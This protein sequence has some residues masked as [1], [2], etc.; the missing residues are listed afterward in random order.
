MLRAAEGKISVKQIIKEMVEDGIDDNIRSEDGINS[1]VRMLGR[2]PEGFESAW[3]RPSFREDISTST[4]FILDEHVPTGV[5]GRTFN[6]VKT[7]IKRTVGPN[8][9]T[10][11]WMDGHIR[12][13]TMRQRAQLYLHLRTA[14]KVPRDAARRI[15]LE[16]LY[17]WDLVATHG[18]ETKILKRLFPW[19]T[20]QKNL[21]M[22]MGSTLMESGTMPVSE[23]AGRW[24]TGRTRAQRLALAYRL[25]KQTQYETLALDEDMDEQELLAARFE[26][27]LPYYYDKHGILGAYSIDYEGRE[28][29][30]YEQ[31]NWGVSPPLMGL[32]EGYEAYAEIGLHLALTASIAMSGAI[33][34]VSG[35]AEQV[36]T[37]ELQESTVAE[38]LDAVVKIMIDQ[39]MPQGSRFVESMLGIAP[40]NWGLEG[41]EVRLNKKAYLALAGFPFQQDGHMRKVEKE[42]QAPFY[43]WKPPRWMD[44]DLARGFGLD[45]ASFIVGNTKEQYSRNLEATGLRKKLGDVPG[46]GYLLGMER[47]PA[48]K[49]ILESIEAA[50][51]DV[52]AYMLA[53]AQLGGILNALSWDGEASLNIETDRKLRKVKRPQ[54]WRHSRMRV[55]SVGLVRS[56]AMCPLREKPCVDCTD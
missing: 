36:P 50:G 32:L 33:R 15:V 18:I 47:E 27:E 35:A 21:M 9:V 30:A 12:N 48:M 1:M 2:D 49:A 22:Q 34:L 45:I 16:A 42:G 17:D 31:K 53:I 6:G 7:V 39:M 52:Q 29:G 46:I 55:R 23:A 28:R 10:T 20:W 8:N 44:S 40:P 38:Q 3:T 41:A 19:Y 37:Y 54:R 5:A 51:G 14:K 13:V 25:R 43:V 11:R 26:M 4:S 24:I 56:R